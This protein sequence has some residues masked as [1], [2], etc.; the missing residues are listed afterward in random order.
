MHTKLNT[1]LWARQQGKYK[2]TTAAIKTCTKTLSK[3]SEINA[4]FI[5]CLKDRKLLKLT[6]SG[7]L[8]RT[9]I[10]L[11]EKK[12]TLTLLHLGLYNLY[13]CQY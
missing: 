9:L 13:A 3:C 6:E 5:V 12:Y 10:T 1:K 4:V 7:K 11:Q 2:N 8:F